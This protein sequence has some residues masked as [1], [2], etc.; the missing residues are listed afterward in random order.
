MFMIPAFI[1]TLV[2][3]ACVQSGVYLAFQL[4]LS[5]QLTIG[6]NTGP[7]HDQCCEQLL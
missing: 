5:H 2:Y 1:K 4:R 7:Q 3:L 6:G